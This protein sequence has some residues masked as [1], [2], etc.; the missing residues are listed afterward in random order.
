ME[1]TQAIVNGVTITL[2]QEQLDFINQQSAK[3]S[4][5][6]RFLELISD[7]DI[8][9]PIVNLVT[10][11]SS[12]FWGDSNDDRMFEYDWGNECFWVSHYRIWSIF[13]KEYKMNYDAVEAFMRTMVEEHFKLKGVTCSLG[14]GLHPD[15]RK[16]HLKLK[17]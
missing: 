9:R 4:K 1:K 5:E 2:T 10:Y 8:S 11:P 15:W 6:E 12:L 7:I 13:Y 16:W 17:L 14:L 3:K